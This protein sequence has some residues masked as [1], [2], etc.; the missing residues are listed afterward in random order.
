MGV[1]CQKQ[2]PPNSPQQDS[3]IPCIP[4]EKTLWQPTPGQG[5]TQWLEDLFRGKQPPFPFLILAFASN[6]LTLPPCVEPSQH[7][8]PPIPGPSQLSE[9]HENAS[10]CEPEP[11]VA[12]TQSMEEPFF[13]L[14]FLLFSW[15]QLSLTPPSTISSLPSYPH[16]G[17]NH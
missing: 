16:L 12:L 3:P 8:E 13:L 17:N 1:K 14:L 5:G 9:P 2:N 6:E 4:C 11:E 15:S 7:D 10:T